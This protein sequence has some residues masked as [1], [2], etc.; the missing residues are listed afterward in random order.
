MLVIEGLN[1]FFVASLVANSSGFINSEEARDIIGVALK[2]GHNITITVDDDNDSITI[3]H[4]TNQEEVEDIVGNLISANSSNI[5][6]NYDDD[7]GTLTI[8][9]QIVDDLVS[10]DTDKSLSANQ[11]KVLKGITD[12]L[13]DKKAEKSQDIN[14]ETKYT[15]SST[16]VLYKMYIEDGDIVLEEV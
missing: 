15:D 5:Q 1:N 16:D 10:T 13:N 7:N 9:T 11:G 6:V 2:S 14:T 4:T 3:D 12:D 8:D